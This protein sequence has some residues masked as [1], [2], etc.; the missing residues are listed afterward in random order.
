MRTSLTLLHLLLLGVF[1]S[2]NQVF[3]QMPEQ[4]E[5]TWEEFVESYEATFRSED[6]ADEV[7]MDELLL[8]EQLV[9]HPMQLNR[10]TR[11][12]LLL[13]PF[14]AEQQVDSILDYRKR[15]YGFRSMGELQLV[16]GL[17]FFARQALS[18]F[19]RCDSAWV[20]PPRSYGKQAPIALK[21]HFKR[22]SHEWET[23]IDLPLYR[24]Q[25]D[26]IP[27]KPTPTNYYTGA[28]FRH[29]LRYRYH[30]KRALVYGVTLETDPGEPLARRGFYPYDYLSA[31]AYFRPVGRNW[32][33]VVGDYEL[34]HGEGL[35]FG[36]QF[37]A[38]REGSY[39]SGRRADFR[40]RPHTG[41]DES[42]F[43]RG[44]AGAYQWKKLHLAAFVSYQ[45]KD[46]RLSETRPVVE[47]LYQSGL[48]RTQ[49]E[50]SHRRT[51]GELCVGGS[52]GWKEK[53]W[54]LETAGAFTSFEYFIYPKLNRYNRSY[55]R[56]KYAGNVSVAHYL[57][58]GRSNW[59][60][61]I[62]TNH[63]G[64]IATLQSL[65]IR[66]STALQLGAQLRYFSP[67]YFCFY[68]DALQQGSRVSNEQ[69]FL[70][71]SRW[72]PMRHWEL[73]GYVDFFRFP[74]PTFLTVLSGAKGMELSLQSKWKLSRSW[75]LGLRY[76]MKTRQRTVSGQELMEYRQVHR[77]RC[78]ASRS[79]RQYD[80]HLQADATFATRQTQP[81]TLGW[82]LSSR[83][84]WRPSASFQLKGFAG[85]FFTDNFESAVYAYEPQ[86]LHASSF[87][88]YF[89]HG[90]RA[91]LITQ[92]QPLSR[93]WLALRFSTLRYFNRDTISSGIAE[94]SSPWKND[95]S[96]QLR[97]TL[98]GK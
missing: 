77:L 44:G 19:V 4:G 32:A 82:M 2:P 51:L 93:L 70:F 5:L 80:V 63:L 20:L 37:F 46:A 22:A 66:L 21:E 92:W 28:P 60:G 71:S 16:S 9:Q 83:A 18:L 40:F 3:A 74:Q 17:D 62:A 30:Y 64:R 55:F 57:K 31:Y 59:Q 86:L 47:T 53:H 61:E 7:N 67:D 96:L 45:K 12:D 27:D 23:R 88:S 10:L 8:L 43:F 69:G 95:L 85:L 15:K 91:V 42:R 48:H 98:P 72:L 89:Y 87:P 49:S 50:I 39:H 6:E 52:V 14:L 81:L 29:L 94:I 24:R 84:S 68:G 36:K 90:A 34:Q 73:T 54:G 78:F 76:R 25:G 58:W 13:L 35:V 33:W 75:Q 56:G 38:N 11:E 97:Y 79:Q 1:V 26:R 65:S 41:T